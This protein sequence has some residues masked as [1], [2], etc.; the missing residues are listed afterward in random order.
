MPLYHAETTGPVVQRRAKSP[1][2]WQRGFTPHRHATEVAMLRLASFILALGLLVTTACGSTT[3]YYRSATKKRTSCCQRLP[4][5][6]ERDGCVARINKVPPAEEKT[7]LNQQ[8]FRCV[9]QNWTCDEKT[10]QPT[11]ESAQKQL[12]CINSLPS[13]M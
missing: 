11:R 10:G 12:N 6:G 7:E 3:N 5:G 9:D 1:T 8:T 4:E 2:D 13:S